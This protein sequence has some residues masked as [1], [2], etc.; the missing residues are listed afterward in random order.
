MVIGRLDAS[1]ENDN[2]LRCQWRNDGVAAASSDG[3]PLVGASGAPDKE[4]NG[5][6]GPRPEKVT[7]APDGCVILI[8][9]LAAIQLN[10]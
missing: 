1:I 3:A 2:S 5:Q 10:S 8:D 7:G 9:T 4:R 6:R